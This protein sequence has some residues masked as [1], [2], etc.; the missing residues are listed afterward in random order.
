[1][2]EFPLLTIGKKEIRSEPK[3]GIE[4]RLRRLETPCDNAKE[5]QTA[6]VLVL[7]MNYLIL[8]HAYLDSSPPPSGSYDPES[9]SCLAAQHPL[10]KLMNLVIQKLYLPL[11]DTLL[12]N[13]L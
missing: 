4:E 13:M 7:E 6:L 5:Y 2:C 1:M 8:D 10:A 3:T 11:L 12:L 9:A